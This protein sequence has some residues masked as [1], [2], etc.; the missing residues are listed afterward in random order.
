[1]DRG[2]QSLWYLAKAFFILSRIPTQNFFKRSHSYFIKQRVLNTQNVQ[3]LST[4][5]FRIRL[6]HYS[7]LRGGWNV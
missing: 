5:I 4:P 7:S 6:L 2:S 3:I 1:M